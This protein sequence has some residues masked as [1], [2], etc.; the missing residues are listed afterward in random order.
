M[1]APLWIRRKFFD[2]YG[3]R[4]VEQEVGMP[5]MGVRLSC[6]CCGYPTLG[7]SGAYEICFLCNW[8]DDG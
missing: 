1:N 3:S 2:F 8:E 7:A 4:P 5:P 6:P